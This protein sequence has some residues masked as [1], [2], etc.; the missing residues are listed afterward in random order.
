MGRRLYSR[1]PWLPEGIRLLSLSAEPGRTRV[2]WE[3][4]ADCACF[5][6]HFDGAPLL[7]GITHLALV[8]QAA[9]RMAAR[10]CV[11]VEVKS[12][13]LRQP[14]GPGDRIEGTVE[15]PDAE[16]RVRFDFRVGDRP[17]AAGVVVVSLGDA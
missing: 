2:A 11:L 3:V 13:R 5:R 16:G 14:V 9:A 17:A 4:A 1:V 12:L 6:G 10:E 8:T 15:G 7:P